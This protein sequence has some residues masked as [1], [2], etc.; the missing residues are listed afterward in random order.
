MAQVV[1]NRLNG[2]TFQVDHVVNVGMLQDDLMIFLSVVALHRRVREFFDVDYAFGGER[3]FVRRDNELQVLF[4][5]RVF[6]YV[7]VFRF[8]I[9]A[10]RCLIVLPAKEWRGHGRRRW[11]CGLFRSRAFDTRDWDFPAGGQDTWHWCLRLV[12]IANHGRLRFVNFRGL[13]ALLRVIKAGS[14]VNY[15]ALEGD[16]RVFGGCSNQDGSVRHF[17]RYSQLVKTV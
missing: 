5:V 4:Y 1:A 14:R 17:D 15:L 12:W 7:Q 2:L 3:R 13:H 10:F 11:G 9:Y 8:M 16:M 6:L